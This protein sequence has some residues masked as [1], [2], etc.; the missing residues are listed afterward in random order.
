MRRSRGFRSRTRNKLKGGRFSIA[1][2]LQTFKNGAKVRIHLNPAVHSGMPHP[3]YQGRI[4]EVLESRG[5]AFIVGVKDGGLL[6]KF[7]CR[8][9]HLKPEKIQKKAEK[10]A[11]KTAKPKPKTAKPKSKPLEKK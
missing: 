5:R 9:E 7:T 2:A 8:P 4:G 11:E 6:K 1:E 3:R 10:P